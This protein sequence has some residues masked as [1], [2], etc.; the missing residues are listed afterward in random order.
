M[1]QLIAKSKWKTMIVQAAL[2]KFSVQTE[3]NIAFSSFFANID[4]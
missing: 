3:E 4:I 1:V 2:V